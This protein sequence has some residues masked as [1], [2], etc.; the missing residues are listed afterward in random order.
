MDLG[1]FAIV[2]ALGALTLWTLAGAVKSLIDDAPLAFFTSI[3][4][5]GVCIASIVA[6][7]IEATREGRRDA[8]A[9]IN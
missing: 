4:L 1:R 7:V 3:I 2:T 8:S 6:N 5:G 9:R